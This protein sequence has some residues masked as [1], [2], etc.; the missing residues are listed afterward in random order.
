L[1]A[2]EKAKQS[3]KVSVKVLPAEKAAR[4]AEVVV[5]GLPPGVGY[6]RFPERV[7]VSPVTAPK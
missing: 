2:V 4:E 1:L 6:R 7:K 5:E 3:M